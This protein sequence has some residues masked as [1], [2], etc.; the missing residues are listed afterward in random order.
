MFLNNVYGRRE[1]S[2]VVHTHP[3]V[4]ESLQTDVFNDRLWP[5]VL[6]LSDRNGPVVQ[7]RAVAPGQT[8]DV[9][10]LRL[11]AI[12]VSHVVPTFGY[13]VDDGTS[14]VV[15]SSDSRETDEIWR[16]A[17]RLPHL[18]AAFIGVAFPDEESRLAVKAGHLTPRSLKRE[19]AKL[20]VHI[21]IVVVHIKP[22]HAPVV[23]GQLGALGLPNLAIGCSGKEY[24]YGV[25][26]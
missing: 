8:I 16:T 23:I 13:I 17:A 1:E 24:L 6:R 11:T 3:Q 14:A 20:P 21:H 9:A 10:G 7:F 12:P 25:R 18:K 19:A 26:S 4:L 5:N 22:T 2:V 15:I